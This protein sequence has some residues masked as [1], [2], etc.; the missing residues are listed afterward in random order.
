MF[1]CLVFLILNIRFLLAS[2]RLQRLLRGASGENLEALLHDT[3]RACREAE[4]QLAELRQVCRKLEQAVAKSLQH[5]GF[6]RFNAFPDMGSELSF[7]I[8]LLN[9]EGDGIVL[10]CLVS[11]DDCRLYAKPVVKRTSPYPLSE[12]EKT[13]IRIACRSGAAGMG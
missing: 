13:V 6:L 3:I 12:E 10:C 9:S 2:R 8:A 4:G 7:A 1:L 11:R 5:V